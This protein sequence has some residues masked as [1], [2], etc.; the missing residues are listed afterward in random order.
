ML[1]FGSGSVCVGGGCRPLS[2]LPRSILGFVLCCIVFELSGVRKEN[3]G[4]YTFTR[5]GGAGV[6]RSSSSSSSGNNHERVK[7]P[8]QRLRKGWNTNVE[9]DSDERSDAV[10]PSATPDNGGVV[11]EDALNLANAVGLQT[12]S[13]LVS[14]GQGPATEPRSAADDPPPKVVWIMS[15]GGSVRPSHPTLNS[16]ERS[17]KARSRLTSI[18]LSAVLS[19]SRERRTRSRIWSSSQDTRPGPTTPPT[20]ART[21]PSFLRFRTGPSFI[22]RPERFRPT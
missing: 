11:I 15:F 14:G 20:F 21:S 13:S 10:D 2:V 9:Q 7:G 3:G 5:L 6:R 4:R 17:M 8:F 12:L 1:L 18:Y 19:K 22:C 16:C